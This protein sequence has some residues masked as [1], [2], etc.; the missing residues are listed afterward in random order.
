VGWPGPTPALYAEL[1]IKYNAY[2]AANAPGVSTIL[3]LFVGPGVSA[4]RGWIYTISFLAH[5][6]YID[7]ELSF[8]PDGE[9]YAGWATSSFESDATLDQGSPEYGSFLVRSETPLP[10]T[11]PLFATGLGAL[12][13]LGWRRKRKN[14]AALAAA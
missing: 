13:L 3:N 9:P 6:S 7:L 14:A 8:A 2:I 4:T 1:G 5:T 12:G 10:A 11:L